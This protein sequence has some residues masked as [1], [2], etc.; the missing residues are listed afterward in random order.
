MEEVI[1]KVDVAILK[2]DGTPIGHKRLYNTREGQIDIAPYLRHAAEIVAPKRVATADIFD[3]GASMDVMV[4]VAGT[5][6]ALFTFMA[7]RIEQTNRFA[8]LTEQISHRVMAYGDFDTI[9]YVNKSGLPVKVLIEGCEGSDI[10]D[11]LAIESSDKGQ[12]AIAITTQDFRNA[13]KSIS[14]TILYDGIEQERIEYEIREEMA[15]AQRVMWLNDNLSP[16]CYTFPLRK[17]ILVE[18]TRRRMATLWGREAASVEGDGELKLISAYEPQAQLKALSGILSSTKVWIAK[19]SDA[20]LAD[21]RTERAMIT[22]GEGMGFI[23]IDLRAAEE[24]AE[25]W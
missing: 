2:R 10:V 17:S 16:E 12:R 9:G 15:G 19:N 8:L 5:R 21:M 23:E 22:P 1:E 4:E 18:A 20:M 7:A 11:Q 14:V 13:V 6:T 25:L 24:G 3:I